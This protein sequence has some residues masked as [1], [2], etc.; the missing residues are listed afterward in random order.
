MSGRRI[1][2]SLALGTA[3]T[4]ILV[5]AVVL[6]GGTFGQRCEA[7]GYEGAAL[8]RC[9]A[10]VSDGGPIYEENIGRLGQ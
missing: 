1:A 10:R 3:L 9:V 4:A 7:A 5:I 6:S 8:E 2:V